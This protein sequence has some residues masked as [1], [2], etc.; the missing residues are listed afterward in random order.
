MPATVRSSS[1]RYPTRPFSVITSRVA[2]DSASARRRDS[3][4]R[5]SGFTPVV[6]VA[7][8]VPRRPV[9]GGAMRSAATRS[10]SPTPV[11][12]M[13]MTFRTPDD[14]VLREVRNAGSRNVTTMSAGTSS[15]PT[16]NHF[17]R[18]RS[19]YSRLMTTQS[20]STDGNLRLGA[21]PCDVACVRGPD[22]LEE[23]LMQRRMNELEALDRGARLDE[24]AQQ[25]LWVGFRR[26][27]DLERP[28]RVVDAGDERLVS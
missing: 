4:I 26:Q 5:R 22:T 9:A 11:A 3:T 18:T 15:V 16:R 28:I 14:A 17:E 25:P 27:L 23:D 1:T 13:T 6:S 10:P 21:G 2:V 12:S 7:A 19:R 24:L 8:S 20:L